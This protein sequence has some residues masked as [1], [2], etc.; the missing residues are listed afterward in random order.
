[1][2][3]SCTFISQNRNKS[4]ITSKDGTQRK[5]KNSQANYILFFASMPF[6]LAPAPIVSLILTMDAPEFAPSQAF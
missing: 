6:S 2:I 5:H 3:H 4:H 1:M